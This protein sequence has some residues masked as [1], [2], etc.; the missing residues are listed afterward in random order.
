MNRS[1]N[2]LRSRPGRLAGMAAL[3]AAGLI[4]ATTGCSAGQIAQTTSQ[5]SAVDGAEGGA[6]DVVLRD[7]RIQATQDGAGIPAGSTVELAFLA[8]NQ[9]LDNS[10]E[11]LTAIKTDIGKV[12][13]TGNRK[14]AAGARLIVA[15]PNAAD[16]VSPA[17]LKELRTVED[18]STATA[19]LA[20][21]KP[22]SNGLSYEFTFEFK[23]AGPIAV[24]VP[25]S[26]GGAEQPGPAPAS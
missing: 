25:I 12:T 22:I 18:A 10:D 6:G 16:S 8:S 19:T 24:S 1:D 23:N 4:A 26:A 5:A 21:D 20:L 7:V 17:A 2:R 13:L 14:L 11:E 3:A 15:P 9:S